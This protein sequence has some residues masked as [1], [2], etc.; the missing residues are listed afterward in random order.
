MRCQELV[1]E[2]HVVIK[3]F[4]EVACFQSFDHDL[5]DVHELI[6]GLCWLFVNV[7][8]CGLQHEFLTGV[9]LP[10]GQNSCVYFAVVILGVE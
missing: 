2:Q 5:R 7:L 8:F 4:D 1:R 3:R 6:F 10:F 9:I